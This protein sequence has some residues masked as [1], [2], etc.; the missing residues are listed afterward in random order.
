MLQRDSDNSCIVHFSDLLPCSAGMC[1]NGGSCYKT[2][3]HN[4]CMCAP[5]YSGQH[6]ETGSNTYTHTHAHTQ[7]ISAHSSPQNH[8]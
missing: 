3:A 2:G 6:C 4:I 1:K 5:G 7:N 8:H